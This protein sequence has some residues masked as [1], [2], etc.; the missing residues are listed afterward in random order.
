MACLE[1]EKK[2]IHG[3]V[4][5]LIHGGQEM[6]AEDFMLDLNM[7]KKNSQQSHWST[8]RGWQ[9]DRESSQQRLHGTGE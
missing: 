3:V 8:W 7:L 5:A 6:H 9:S 4:K 1:E 2:K